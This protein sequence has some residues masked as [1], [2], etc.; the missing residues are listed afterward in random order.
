MGR[1][2][3]YSVDDALQGRATFFGGVMTRTRR[4]STSLLVITALG[5]LGGCVIPSQQ[6]TVVP[7]RVVETPK[8]S[9]EATANT[10]V[11]DE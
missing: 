2:A 10:S 7:K 3:R 11:L 8:I 9:P 4:L 1:P 5:A 6:D